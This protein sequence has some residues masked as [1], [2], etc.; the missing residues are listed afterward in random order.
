MGL[1]TE[2]IAARRD[3]FGVWRVLDHTQLDWTHCGRVFRTT[4]RT[5][6]ARKW[7]AQRFTSHRRRCSRCRTL[8]RIARTYSAAEGITR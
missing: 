2:T 3:Q 4:G 7:Q 6:N 5:R 1:F 8:R